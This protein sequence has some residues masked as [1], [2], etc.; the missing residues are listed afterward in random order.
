VLTLVLG[1]VECGRGCAV[2]VDVGAF[3]AGCS[4]RWSWGAGREGVPDPAV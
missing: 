1:W 2:R 3:I 4:R